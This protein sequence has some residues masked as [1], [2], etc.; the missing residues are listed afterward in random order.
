MPSLNPFDAVGPAYGRMKTLLFRPFGLDRWVALG[1][2]CFCQM[3]AGMGLQNGCGVPSVPGDFSDP[4]GHSKEHSRAGE[5]AGSRRNFLAALDAERPLPAD[6]TFPD[7][8]AA[9]DDAP[10]GSQPSPTDSL[11]DDLAAAQTWV[12]A[13][14]EL[15][16]AIA[17]VLVLLGIGLTILFQWLGARAAFAYLDNVV[18]GRAEVEQPWQRHARLANSFWRWRLGYILLA[19]VFVLDLG[20]PLGLMVYRTATGAGA[21]V[22]LFTSGPFWLVTAGLALVLVLAVLA[23]LLLYDLV[24]PLQLLRQSTAGPALSEALH[25]LFAHLGAS[26]LYLV[27]K[28][29]LAAGIAIVVLV[30]GF[31]TCCCGFLVMAIPVL[32]QALLQP[33]W[34]LHRALPLY[35]MRQL[36]PAYDLFA[37]KAGVAVPRP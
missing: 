17:G 34:V 26:L 32:G 18:S 31:L 6:E 27:L 2:L 28:L 12:K 23:D 8:A 13:N 7:A 16:L 19:W 5:P 33:I 36:G 21:W 14:L 35:F 20:I 22:Q 24:L 37:A 4:G 15:V 10:D 30:G 25:L 3:C 29:L 9:D 1:L 11:A